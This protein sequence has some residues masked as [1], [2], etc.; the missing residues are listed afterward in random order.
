MAPRGPF[1]SSITN[2][3]FVN[4][5]NRLGVRPPPPDG[6]D[7]LNTVQ[8]VSIVDSD[9]GIVSA[10]STQLLDVPFSTGSQVNPGTG[11]VLADSGAQN[12][13][14]WLIYS[15]IQG[16]DAGGNPT[17]AIQRRDAANATSIWTQNL[18]GTVTGALQG[19]IWSARVVLQQG[20]RIRIMTNGATTV[21]S[22]FQANLWIFPS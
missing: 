7:L 3:F 4:L 16:I 5:I 19:Y 8:P 22:I 18:I 6:F 14:N 1:L 15:I 13:G 2:T 10:Q 20:E 12:A 17:I 9:I 11:F 21:N